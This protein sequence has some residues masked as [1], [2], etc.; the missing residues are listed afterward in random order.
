MYHR[1]ADGIVCPNAER[2]GADGGAGVVLLVLTQER[3]GE[4]DGTFG[5]VGELFM[6]DGTLV[7]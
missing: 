4:G 3:P 7:A 2:E 6:T 5:I 1:I